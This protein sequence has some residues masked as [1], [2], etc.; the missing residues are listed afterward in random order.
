MV[1]LY[2]HFPIQAQG[3]LFLLTCHKHFALIVLFRKTLDNYRK[4][5]YTRREC[6]M[7]CSLNS[8]I[9]TVNQHSSYYAFEE[10]LISNRNVLGLAVMYQG[11]SGMIFTRRP[12]RRSTL[13][14]ET[15]VPPR[16]W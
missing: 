12:V 10:R 4:L 9:L 15:T 6:L 5:V 3:Q 7:L 11:T 8:C 13:K 2:L 1:E 14:M 16:R